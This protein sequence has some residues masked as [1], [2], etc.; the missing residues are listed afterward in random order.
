MTRRTLGLLAAITTTFLASTASAQD[1]PRVGIVMGYP[2]SIGVMWQVTDGVA[3]RPEVGVQKA[4]N[5]VTATSSPSV[6]GATITNSSV[7]V[8]DN[9]QVGIGLSAL[10]Y[11]SKP[12]KLRTY[13]S[14]RWAYTRTSSTSATTPASGANSTGSTGNGNFVSGS[15]GAQFALARRFS[16][17]GEIG[18]GY[19]RTV[20]APAGSTSATLFTESASWNLATRSGAGIVFYF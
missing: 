4:S 3:L 11:L 9:W 8:N 13:I 2:A 14:P 19:S 17:F 20:V 15:F 5:E 10:F 1:D 7:N 12:D 16:V 6:G 18:L